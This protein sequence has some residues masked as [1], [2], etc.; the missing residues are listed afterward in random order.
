MNHLSTSY[1]GEV[2]CKSQIAADNILDN[3]DHGRYDA[4]SEDMFCL[5]HRS[6]ATGPSSLE[7][8]YMIILAEHI[9]FVY[10]RTMLCYLEL[11]ATIWPAYLQLGSYDFANLS[12]N[13][14]HGN[15]YTDSEFC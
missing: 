9:V 11:T 4:A 3:E 1:S 2:N 6:P 15:C 12:T 14:M 7:E 8:Q 5:Q 10:P 13:L